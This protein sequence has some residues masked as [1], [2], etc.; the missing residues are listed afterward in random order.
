MEFAD[1][2]GWACTV[3]GDHLPDVHE[4]P[5]HIREASSVY[6]CKTGWIRVEPGTGISTGALGYVQIDKTGTRMA[7]YH[8]WGE[9]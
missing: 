9:L 8:L 5:R 4:L 3:L 7:I 2:H 1:A 6:T